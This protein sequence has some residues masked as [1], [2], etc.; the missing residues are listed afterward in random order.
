MGFAF[1]YLA[2]LL[3]VINF[4]S[5]SILENVENLALL[6]VLRMAPC[7]LDSCGSLSHQREIPL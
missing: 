1:V 4:D 2:E 7:N 6:N 5:Y 3:L